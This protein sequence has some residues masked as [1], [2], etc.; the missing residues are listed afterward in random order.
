MQEV[1]PCRND[2]QDI[3]VWQKVFQAARQPGTRV[4][5]RALHAIATLMQRAKTSRRWRTVLKDLE[6]E[7]DGLLSNPEACRLL[8]PLVQHDAKAVGDLTPAAQCKRVRRI[9]ELNTPNELADWVN[10]SLGLQQSKGVNPSHPALIRLW[11]WQQ[12]RITCQPERRSDSKEFLKKAEQWLPEFF[13]DTNV[14]LVKLDSSHLRPKVKPE[15]PVH[16]TPKVDPCEKTL[17]CLESSNPKHRAH[18]LKRLAEIGV[19]DL[20]DWCLMFLEDESREVRIAALQGIIHCD[21]IDRAPLAPLAESTDVS[22]RAAALA[23]LARHGGGGAARWF[24]LGLKDPSACVRLETVALMGRLDRDTHR[25]L[26]ELALHDPNPSV[27]R[28][29]RKAIA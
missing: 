2:V 17:G 26:F 27:V 24:E 22:I 28:F 9:V 19:A 25:S 10:R 15:I 29:A 14:E 6:A 5:G 18:G 11:R 4:R 21:E 1:C 23:V 7:L 16:E 12:N 8:R 3:S 13:Q 20:F